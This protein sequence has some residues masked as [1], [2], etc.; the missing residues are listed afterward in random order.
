MRLLV[1]H[2]GPKLI[3]CS[4]I[5]RAFNENPDEMHA[6]SRHGVA[7]RRDRPALYDE[8]SVGRREPRDHDGR[9]RWRYVTM[10]RLHTR[11]PKQSNRFA[12]PWKT[13]T[14]SWIS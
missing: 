7:G 4:W 14:P 1:D 2:Q 12:D 3:D 6:E 5:C 9:E 8:T 13:S 11:L 10:S